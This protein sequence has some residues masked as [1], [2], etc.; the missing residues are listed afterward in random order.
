MQKAE[1]INPDDF[2]QTPAGRVWTPER[3]RRAWD[4]AYQALG[5]A[6]MALKSQATAEQRPRLYIVCGIQGAGKSTWIRQNAE[7][8]EPPTMAEGLDETIEIDL[9]GM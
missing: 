9:T 2:L 8:F 4:Q 3:N 1:S 5:A 6:L 7:Q